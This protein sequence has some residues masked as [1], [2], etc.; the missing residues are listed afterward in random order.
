MAAVVLLAL[1]TGSTA[2]AAATG[3]L[4]LSTLLRALHAAVAAQSAPAPRP[5]SPSRAAVATA[6]AAGSARAPAQTPERAPAEPERPALRADAPAHTAAPAP[7][8]AHAAVARTPRAARVERTAPLAA[9]APN[10][11]AA[12]AALPPRVLALDDPDELYR[13]AHRVHFVERDWLRALAAWEQ[14]LRAAPAGRFALEARYN[15]ALDLVRL[16][17][18][19][20]ARAALR[21]FVRGDLAGYR[22]REA[23]ALLEA[24]GP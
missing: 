18:R 19:D 11:P 1:G 4:R 3:R 2:W 20:E 9:A 5:S 8:P 17:R 14:Y 15:R 22:Q 23:S 6:N 24:L 21:P 12:A 13:A 10:E 7:G 16:G